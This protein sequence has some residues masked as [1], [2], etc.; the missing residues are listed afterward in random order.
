MYFAFYSTCHAQFNYFNLLLY[1]VTVSINGVNKLNR[2]CALGTR[3]PN[4]KIHNFGE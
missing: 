1:E 2:D 4:Y 3:F